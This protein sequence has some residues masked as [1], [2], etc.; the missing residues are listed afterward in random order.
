MNAGDSWIAQIQ[1]NYIQLQID[2]LELAVGEALKRKR[3]LAYLLREG[4]R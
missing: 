2:L 4:N 3:L 1:R